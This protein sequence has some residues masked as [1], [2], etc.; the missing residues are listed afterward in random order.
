LVSARSAMA[1]LPQ[2]SVDWI[3]AQDIAMVAQTQM[4]EEKKKRR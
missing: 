4:D 3:R 2:G 1:N